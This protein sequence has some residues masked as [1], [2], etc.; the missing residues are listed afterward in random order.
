MR[1]KICLLFQLKSYMVHAWC[2]LYKLRNN[3]IACMFRHSYVTLCGRNELHGVC[4]TICNTI[5]LYYLAIN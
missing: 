1:H 4:A 5:T 3:G 2:H